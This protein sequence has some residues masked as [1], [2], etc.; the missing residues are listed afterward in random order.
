MRPRSGGS[1]RPGTAARKRRNWSGTRSRTSTPG[2]P[3]GTG[4]QG[5]L[6]R[7]RLTLMGSPGRR[8]GRTARNLFAPPRP[9]TRWQKQHVPYACGWPI[10]TVSVSGSCSA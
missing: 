8:R 9:P 10:T 4:D 5:S 2:G 6:F 7:H 3:P 1:Q